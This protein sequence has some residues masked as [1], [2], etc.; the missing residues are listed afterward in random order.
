[1]LTVEEFEDLVRYVSDNVD[2]DLD[3]YAMRAIENRQ[4]VPYELA[5][6]INEYAEEWCN[7]NGIDPDEYYGDYDAED[8]FMHDAYAFDS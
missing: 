5:D 8:V 7:E 6:P 3:R 4:P 1:M 2:H